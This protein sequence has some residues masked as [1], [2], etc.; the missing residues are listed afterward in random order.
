MVFVLRSYR[1]SLRPT[2]AQTRTL[3]VWLRLTRE[4]YNAALQERRDAWVK[5]HK[6]VSLYDQMAA[7]PGVREVRP[8][9]NAIPIVVLRG[10]LRRIDRAFKAF[11]RRCKS[12]ETPG[13]PRFKGRGR[14]ESLL[15]DDLGKKNPLIAGKKRVAVPLLGKIKVHLHRPLEGVPRGMRLKREGDHWYVTFACDGVPTKPL[16]KTGRIVGIDLGLHH[17]IATSDGQ[18]VPNE[19]PG[20]R[21]ALHLA[22]AQRRVTGRKRGSHRRRIA[23]RWLARAHAH[24]ANQRRE[25]HIVIAKAL[26]AAYDVIFVENLNVKGLARGMLAKS[27]SDAGW[28]SFL[29]WLAVKAEEAARENPKVRAAGTSMECPDCG[30]V[31]AKSLRERIHRCACGL[32]CDRDV[33]SARVIE[34][35]GLRLRGGAPLVRGPQ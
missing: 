18:T 16:P 35:R 31:V 14:F 12:G 8:E 22:S 11:F 5:Q 9:F 34:G 3:T 13:Y 4:L 28:A 25:R 1:Y 27:V 2:Q 19:R 20:G 23:V 15:L 21:A 33:A 26:V 7:L 29:W 10:V 30:N 24:V 32:V 6:S 17:F